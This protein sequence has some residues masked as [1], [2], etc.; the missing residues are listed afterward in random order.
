MTPVAFVDEPLELLTNG[1]PL[2]LE[3]TLNSGQPFPW[4]EDNGWFSGVVRGCFIKIRQHPDETIEFRTDQ[5]DDV[6]QRLLHSYF[7]LD[8]DIAAIYADISRD[9]NIAQLVKQYRGLRILRQDPWECLVAYILSTRSPIERTALNMETLG[10]HLGDPV[11]LGR[12][13][14]G[15][16][17]NPGTGR[18][19]RRGAVGSVIGGVCF[20]PGPGVQGCF[21]SRARPS[22][23]GCLDADFPP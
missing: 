17:P 20:L 15:F 22:G 16:V 19:S 6:A 14:S 13:H 7:R 11:S 1:Q 4:R 3:T 12:R 9:P 10:E 5:P 23:Y 18:P 8:D 2:D 21:G